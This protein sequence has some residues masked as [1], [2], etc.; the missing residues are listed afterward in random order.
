VDLPDPMVEASM[1]EGSEVFL[2]H[3]VHPFS[4][5]SILRLEE[6]V[7]WVGPL[8]DCLLDEGFGYSERI[9]VGELSCLGPTIRLSD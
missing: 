4:E 1:G 8:L 7:T 6:L 2:D 9:V 3:V 5:N